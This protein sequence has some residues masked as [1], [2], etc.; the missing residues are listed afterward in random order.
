MN[1]EHPEW[2]LRTDLL[3]DVG[4]E[5]RFSMLNE[6]ADNRMRGAYYHLSFPGIGN[7]YRSASGF[8]FRPINYAVA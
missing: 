6:L 5:T 4:I 7:I 1:I 8:R 2:H 3:P